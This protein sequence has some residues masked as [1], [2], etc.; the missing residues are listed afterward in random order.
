M[1]FLEKGQAQPRLLKERSGHAEAPTRI[2]F[3]GGLD[4]PVM[5]GARHLISCSKDGNLRDIS[6]LNEFMSMNFSQKKQLKT[7]NDGVS[8]GHGPVRQFDFSQYRERDWQN[9]L[10]CH[11]SANA[12][13]SRPFLWSYANHT[14]SKIPV[15]STHVNQT[16][17]TSVAV[18][19]C[20][21]FGV[22]G[23]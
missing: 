19:Q 2:R 16:P 20:G 18:S 7:M 23:F 8:T 5:Q 17:V 13:E 15:Q 21:N 6:L 22:L 4:D 10:T 12:D 9:V 1:W 14:I 3:Y 11:D